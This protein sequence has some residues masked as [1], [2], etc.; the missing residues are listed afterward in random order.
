M[1]PTKISQVPGGGREPGG[2]AGQT[3]S[4]VHAAWGRGSTELRFQTPGSLLRVGSLRE[5]PLP[6]PCLLGD[7]LF[8]PAMKHQE[9][10]RPFSWDGELGCRGH[11]ARSPCPAAVPH[12]W[13]SLQTP[14][15]VPPGCRGMQCGAFSPTSN[16]ADPRSFSDVTACRGSPGSGRGPSSSGPR[17]CSGG[18]WPH[19]RELEAH[20]PLALHKKS[21]QTQCDRIARGLGPGRSSQEEAKPQD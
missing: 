3:G 9:Q 21:R 10:V 17:A 16:M 11:R 7:I 1:V 13:M 19:P 8:Y 4:S 18:P 6:V 14:V 20:L 2:L 15:R 5:C 12:H